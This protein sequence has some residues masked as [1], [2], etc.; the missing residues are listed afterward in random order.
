MESKGYL[1]DL[2][3]GIE[4]RLEPAGVVTDLIVTGRT[5]LVRVQLPKAASDALAAAL[6]ALHPVT[7]ASEPGAAQTASGPQGE[8]TSRG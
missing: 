6:L 7:G 5:A 1:L 8:E 2:G 4:I 3:H